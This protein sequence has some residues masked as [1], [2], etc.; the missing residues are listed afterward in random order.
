MV[1]GVL[2]TALSVGLLLLTPI[3]FLLSLERSAHALGDRAALALGLA[4]SPLFHLV[5]PQF[6]LLWTGLA[7]G[8]LAFGLERGLRAWKGRR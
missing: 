8:T 5:A 3:Y 1:A 7:G 2:P 4:L 6:D